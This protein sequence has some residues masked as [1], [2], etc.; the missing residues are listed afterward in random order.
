MAELGDVNGS[1]NAPSPD[2][3]VTPLCESPPVGRDA[4]MGGQQ[5]D[6]RLAELVERVERVESWNADLEDEVAR[7]RDLIVGVGQ[8]IAAQ[9]TLPTKIE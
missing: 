4:E 6:D 5:H 9:A 3:G 8:S 7:L 2:E 1:F